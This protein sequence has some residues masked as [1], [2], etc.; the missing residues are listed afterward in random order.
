MTMF[1]YISPDKERALRVAREKLSP[2][3]AKRPEELE[4][5]LPLGSPEECTDRLGELADAGAQ[6]VH[7]W[8]IGDY[9]EQLE[10]IAKEVTP[11]F[12]QPL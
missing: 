1:C 7:L 8:P 6:R 11:A 4:K 9:I 3:L 2:A 10:I 12:E 5:L